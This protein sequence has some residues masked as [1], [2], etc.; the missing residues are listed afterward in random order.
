M[1]SREPTLERLAIAEQL[2]A[3]PFGL[4]EITSHDLGRHS[5]PHQE[6]MTP[7]CTFN[8]PAPKA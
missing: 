7:I 5:G 1:I 6:W 8:T 2:V 3:E 4:D